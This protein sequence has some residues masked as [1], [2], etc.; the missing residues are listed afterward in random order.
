MKKR[1]IL[2]SALLLGANSVSW[3]SDSHHA[4]TESHSK[5]ESHAA[6]SDHHPKVQG[7]DFDT[8]FGWLKN[9]NTRYVKRFYRNDG[10]G[11]EERK[12]VVKGQKPHSIVLSCSDSRVPPELIFDQGLGEIFVVRVAGEALDSSFIASIEYAVEHLGSKLI[13]V[14]GHQSCGAVKAALE[15]QK[16]K[17]V[18]SQSLDK[19]VGDIRPRLDFANRTI[20][21]QSPG[22]MTESSVNA[23]GVAKD[24]V[25]RSQIVKNKVLEGEL[26]IVSGIYSLETGAVEF[27]EK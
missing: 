18:G 5:P 19:L 15:S 11:V 12:Q 3:A 1:T 27:F 20:A 2:M 8:A 4:K 7:V 13:V 9:G 23:K 22:L 21:S 6:K 10:K 26:K 16:G 14:L 24:L 17:T 25:E